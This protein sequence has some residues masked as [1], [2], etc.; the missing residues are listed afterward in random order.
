M[1]ML[2]YFLAITTV[3]VIMSLV[4]DVQIYMYEVTNTACLSDGLNGVCSFAAIA[5]I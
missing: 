4:G 1:K 3:V 2:R 5:S